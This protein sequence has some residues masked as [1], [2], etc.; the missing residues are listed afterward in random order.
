M[1][2]SNQ[3][4][5]IA[6]GTTVHGNRVAQVSVGIEECRADPALRGVLVLINGRDYAILDM[7][8]GRDYIKL[9]AKEDLA[10]NGLDVFFHGGLL[11]FIYRET[12]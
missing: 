11:S 10:G 8:V 2:G 4:D 6:R 5:K 7:K 12:K 3:R 1:G 9:L